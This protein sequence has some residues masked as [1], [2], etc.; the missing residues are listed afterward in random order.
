MLMAELYIAAED[1]PQARRT[2]GDLVETD[3]TTRS[4]TLMAAIE[5]GQG[6]SDAVVQGW[7]A[8]ALSVPRGPQWICENCHNIH[9]EWAPICG[10]CSA[11]DTLAW[12][13]PPASELVMPGGSE[14]LPLLI[15]TA[16]PEETTVVVADDPNVLEAEDLG[17]PP[18]KA[19]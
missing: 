10:N 16:V 4:V 3:P 18:S 1:F 8:K 11:F 5:R 13:R 15:G 2:L 14:M 9:S 12:K 7:L 19:I 6:S 17:N